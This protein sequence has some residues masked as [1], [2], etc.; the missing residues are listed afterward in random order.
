VIWGILKDAGMVTAYG[1]LVGAAG[2][3]SAV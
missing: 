2:F 3:E 1:K